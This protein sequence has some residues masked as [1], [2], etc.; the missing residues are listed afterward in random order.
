MLLVVLLQHEFVLSS[1]LETI[2]IRGR[3]DVV[4]ESASL[5]GTRP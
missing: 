3:I 5:V 4:A 2:W 1:T